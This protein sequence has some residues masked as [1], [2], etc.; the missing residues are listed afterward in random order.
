MQNKQLRTGRKLYLLA[1]FA[2]YLSA[3][4]QRQTW[5]PITR[6]DLAIREVPGNPGAPAIQLYYSQMINDRDTNNE[7]EYIYRRIKI[8][9][10]KGID[11]A[12]VAILVPQGDSLSELKARTIHRDGTI[13][14]FEARPFEKVVARGRGFK[15]IVKS[16]TF[17]EAAVGSIL[18]YRYKLN[19]PAN[20]LPSHEWIAQHDLYTVKEEFDIR[21]YIGPIQGIDGMV[22]LSLFQTLPRDARI[23]SKGEGF[24]LEMEN[25]PAFEDE[26]QM[27]PRGT[28]L[29]H[30]TMAYGGGEMASREKFWRFAAQRWNDEA[31]A[32]MGDLKA[33]K[34][35]A[36]EAGGL[37]KNPE[38]RLRRL[39]A[40]AQQVRNLSYERERTE[41]EVLKENLKP[42]RNAAEI[43][44]RGYGTRIE[45]TRLFVAMAR[46]A[47][48]DASILRISNR[49]QR[50][51]D[52]NVLDSDQMDTEIAL[53]S[54]NGRE[55]YLDP[56]TQF[57]PFGLLRWMRT[58]TQALKLDKKG[59][60]FLEIPMATYDQAVVNRVAEVSFEPDGDI[61][62]ELTVD[63]KG[64][65]ALERRLDALETDEAGR[66]RMLEDEVRSWLPSGG[67]AKLKNSSGWEGSGG[68]LTASFSIT[69]PNYA[70]LAGSRLVIARELFQERE[71][72]A[73]K[74][75]DRRFPVYF[76]YAFEEDDTVTMRVPAGFLVESLPPKESANIGFAGY[77]C[78][79]SFEGGQLSSR[80][81]LRVNGI[82]FR[83]DQ[84]SEV[85]AFFNKVQSGDQ[86]QA[87]LQGGP[88]HAQN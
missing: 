64:S 29:Y 76:P 37:E 47:G 43:L 1:C 17:P 42:N 82:F 19:Y 53:V 81:V 25:V 34:P 73:F 36:L 60:S 84:Y 24:G 66:A 88:I 78:Q 40:R 85:R 77:Q 22:G 65:E 18:E 23:Q 80:R 5:L 69:V 63:F 44:T 32:F 39:Y 52:A 86:E 27:P 20:I 57:C 35:A 48:F 7:G 28:Y 68:P 50:F 87:V 75:P 16:F 38:Q 30:V 8:L 51:F 70:A 58:S 45:I 62:G 49:S 13:V 21:A 83:A 11:Y 54:L 74:Q 10:E 71:A 14:D 9:N 67:D 26:P 61:T 33:I 59:G 41:D 15:E 3:A 2:F 12:N 56:G 79:S 55:M 72:E 46:A 4:A 31:E 6:D